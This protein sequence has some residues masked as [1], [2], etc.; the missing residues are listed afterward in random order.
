[1]TQI[2]NAMK[3]DKYLEELKSLMH[4][5][6]IK[7]ITGIRRCGKSYLLFNLFYQ[8]LKEIG[9]DERHIIIADIENYKNRSLRKPDALYEYIENQIV[10]NAMH[11]LLL[12][13]VQLV[14][15]FEGVLNG[16]LHKPNL[17]IY[18][19]GSNARFLSKDVITE[20]RGRGYEVKLY[21]LSFSEFMQEYD[22]TVQSALHE[23]MIYGSLPQILS[24][25]T[26]RAKVK[27]LKSLFEETYLRD[28][29]DRYNI[30]NDCDIEELIDLLASGIGSLTSSNKLAN[31]FRSVKQSSLSYGSIKKY[32]DIFCDAFLIE[33]ATRYDVKGKHYIDSPHKYY[34]TDLG[35]RNARINFRQIEYTHLMENLIYNELR[36]RGYNVDVGIFPIVLRNSEGRQQRSQ[37]EIDFVCNLGSRRLYIQSAYRIESEEKVAQEK[38][39]LMR[40]DDSFQKVIIVG[41]ETPLTRDAHGITTISIYD[42]LTN[43]GI[44]DW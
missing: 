33:K 28:I 30:H 22:G 26:E 38:A 20:F 43:F 42:F 5:G 31:T 19:T 24:L 18:V 37:L 4:N 27:F 2:S 6:L 35:L 25:R 23:F 44:F 3:R 7:V 14:D 29:R 41:Y 1:M 39:S 13:E 12:D 8:Y 10:D 36:I 34:F 15:D 32:L 11:Y 21:P 9:I 40:I 16:M 17:D